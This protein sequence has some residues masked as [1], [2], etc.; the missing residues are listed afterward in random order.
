MVTEVN[1][2]LVFRAMLEVARYMMEEA[3]YMVE[4]GELVKVIDRRAREEVEW[5]LDESFDPL[6]DKWS[7]QKWRQ[8]VARAKRQVGRVLDRE[9]Q[10]LEAVSEV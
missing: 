1:Q 8:Q 4:E 3:R 10:K 9:M 2:R 6:Q 7:K 5:L